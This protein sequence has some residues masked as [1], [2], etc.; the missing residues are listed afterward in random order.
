MGITEA[1]SKKV[2]FRF[3]S[4][5]NCGKGGMK[6]TGKVT[7]ERVE[8][9]KIFRDSLQSIMEDLFAPNIRKYRFSFKLIFIG[10]N[11]I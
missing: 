9:Y 6:S 8:I 7:H 1:I 4:M 2:G 11:I 5:E 10:Y 3:P